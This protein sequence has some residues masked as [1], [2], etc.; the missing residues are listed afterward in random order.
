M[1]NKFALHV[2]V[3]VSIKVVSN[4]CQDIHFYTAASESDMKIFNK[5]NILCKLKHNAVT[6]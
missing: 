2:F 1:I 4:H 6:T 5:K 3:L